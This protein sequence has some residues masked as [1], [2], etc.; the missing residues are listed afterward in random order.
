MMREKV[1][2]DNTALS[3]SLSP[4]LVGSRSEKER[5]EARVMVI[6]Y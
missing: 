2:H 1:S 3:L 5:E 6:D 4:S